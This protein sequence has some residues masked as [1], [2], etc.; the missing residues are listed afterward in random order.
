M[1]F[2]CRDAVLADLRGVSCGTTVSAR[3]DLAGVAV[4]CRNAARGGILDSK[5]M[6]VSGDM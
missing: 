6:D 2:G 3:D 4:L 5:L 1:A